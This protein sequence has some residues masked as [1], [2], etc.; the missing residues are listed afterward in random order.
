MIDFILALFKLKI[1]VTGVKTTGVRGATPLA[2]R[3]RP[4]RPF[5]IVSRST[6]NQ[7]LFLSTGIIAALVGVITNKLQVHDH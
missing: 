2:K 3:F 1:I 6:N 4:F 5:L 7:P